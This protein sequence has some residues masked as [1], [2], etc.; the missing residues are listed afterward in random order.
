MIGANVACPI[1]VRELAGE[2][3]V[4]ATDEVGTLAPWIGVRRCAAEHAVRALLSTGPGY[5]EGDERS[6]PAAATA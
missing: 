3:V 6:V 4:V 5:V 1:T 2:A